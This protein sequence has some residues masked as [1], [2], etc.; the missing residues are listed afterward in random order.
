VRRL[1]VKALEKGVEGMPYLIFIDVNAPA[2]PQAARF[3]KQ[4]QKGVTNWMDRFP[5]PTLESP[6]AYN[7]LYVTNFSPQHDGSDLALPGEWLSVRP[8]FVKT[9]A[10]FDLTG[11][12][13][14]AL[15]NYE[16]VPEIGPGGELRG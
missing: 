3:D 15:N 7:G 9:P 14:H 10:E 4:W 8:L 5:T 11:M 2:E 1:F 13:E 12:L 16:R 6:D